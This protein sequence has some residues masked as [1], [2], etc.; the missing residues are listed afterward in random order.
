MESLGITPNLIA[1]IL[2]GIALWVYM[3]YLPARLAQDKGYNF[4]VTF[5]VGLLAWWATLIVVLVLAPRI[6]RYRLHPTEAG[7]RRL[8]KGVICQECRTLNPGHARQCRHCRTT[9]P[10]INNS[11]T[12]V[13]TLYLTDDV[14]EEVNEGH[15]RVCLRCG[16]LNSPKRVLCKSCGAEFAV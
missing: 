8:S 5:A 7:L 4:R 16:R 12:A 2:L 13:E 6:K 3:A 15:T 9:L 1:T 11:K 14:R 10:F